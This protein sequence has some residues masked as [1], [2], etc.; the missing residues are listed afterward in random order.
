M[1]KLNGMK[2]AILVANGFEQVELVKPRQ[3]LIDE[4]AIVQIVSPEQDKVQGWHHHEKADFF[5]V[6]CELD[7][8]QAKDYDGLLLPGGLM[9]PDTLRINARAVHFIREM[10]QQHKPIAAICHAPWLL[11]N[12]G[13]AKGKN[14]TSYLSVSTDLT[15]AGAHW[16]DKSVVVSGRLVTSRM[17]EDIPQFNEAMIELFASVM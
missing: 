1:S 3:A 6:D 13:L 11:I 2:I 17:P 7:T 4:G 10:D 14:V 5:K 8:A 15:N 9:N 16:L 12:A